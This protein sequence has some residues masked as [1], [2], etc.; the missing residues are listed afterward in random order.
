MNYAIFRVYSVCAINARTPRHSSLTH[1]VRLRNDREFAT[2]IPRSIK[3]HPSPFVAISDLC[4]HMVGKAERI[5]GIEPTSLVWRTKTLPIRHIRI[6][7]AV[8]PFLPTPT[9]PWVSPVAIQVQ[10]VGL[11]KQRPMGSL[12]MLAFAAL[13]HRS[14][15]GFFL[16]TWD[17]RYSRLGSQTQF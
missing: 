2:R 8:H 15:G 4:L 13:H 6:W 5:V 10:T 17:I 11:A 12:M 7:V 16:S 9:R 14:G 1:N 3:L